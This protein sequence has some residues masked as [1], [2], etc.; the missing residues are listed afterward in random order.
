MKIFIS[1]LISGF[2]SQ[3]QAAKS[4]VTTLRHEP[5][6]AE[7]FGAQ[8]N[9]PQVA[10]L[11]GLRQ[12]DLVVL[13]LG[14]AYGAVQPSSGL[15][16]THEE[17]REARGTK[18]VIAFVQQGVTPD[19]RQA[20]FIAE[21][22]GWQGGLFRD[23]FDTA[24]DLQ[25]GIIRALHDFTVANV[26]GAVDQDELGRRAAAMIP[27]ENRNQATSTELEVAIVGGPTQ[28]I[29][30]PVE[31]ES[32][33][34]S[35]ALLQA[36]LFGSDQIFDRAFGSEPTLVDGALAL[37]QDRGAS[38]RLDEEGSLLLHLPLDGA[39]RRRGGADLAR[40]MSEGMVI[41]EEAVQQRLASALG[42]AAA[43]IER[44]DPTQRITDVAIAARISGAQYR[45]WRTR[46]QHAA[47]PGS[48]TMSPVQ[49]E[50]QT[51]VTIQRRAALRLD[52]TRL[53]EDIVVPLRRQFSRG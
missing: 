21:V 26:V 34:L 5:V 19:D 4:A 30:R 1:S 31:I 24:A 32:A 49:G 18:P 13:V 15:S 11:Q 48:M 6:M 10:C 2:A 29:L 20:E 52:R 27:P 51:V 40:G 47:S 44:I 39:G 33:D 41:F 14:E 35:D 17:Y 46:E 25:S 12:S 45:V 8:P 37:R 53:V 16:A 36:A 43:A 50:R 23:G 28:R 22:Q 42:Y 38:L 3:R 7:D 9:S